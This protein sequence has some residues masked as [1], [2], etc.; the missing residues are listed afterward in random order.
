MGIDKCE[1]KGCGQLSEFGV[2]YGGKRACPD[3]F[4]RHYDPNDPMD[5]KKPD[6]W[7]GGPAVFMPEPAA[8][9]SSVVGGGQLCFT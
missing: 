3:C 6:T 2:I 4:L 5:F 1:V 7:A 9:I 8:S